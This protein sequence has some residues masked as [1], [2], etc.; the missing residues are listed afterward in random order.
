MALPTL[1]VRDWA[2][3]GTTTTA[4]PYTDLIPYLAAEGFKVSRNDIDS[5]DAG[6]DSSGKMHR[7]R[8]AIKARVDG[9]CRPLLSTELSTLLTSLKPE[10]LDVQYTDPETNSVR[11]GV[12][13]PVMMYSNNIP[14][15]FLFKKGSVEYWTGVT[16]PLIEA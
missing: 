13:S 11:G 12:N 4:H 10:W 3:H 14:A 8:V 2:Y 15:G 5:S 16:F 1:K 6:R 9:I 7:A